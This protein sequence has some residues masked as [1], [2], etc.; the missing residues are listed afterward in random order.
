MYEDFG[1][2][3]DGRSVE[4]SLFLPDNIVDP[5]QYEGDGD[6]RIHSLQVAGTF[7]PH[8]GTTAWDPA[9]APALTPRPHP[10]GVRWT[11]DLGDLPDGLYQYKYVVTFQNGTVRWCGDPCARYIIGPDEDAGFVVGGPRTAVEPIGTRLPLQDLVVYELMLDDFTAEYRGGAAPVDAVQD[12][13]GHLETLGV[14]AVELM[15]WT[16]W[17]GGSF[18]WGYNPFALFAAED[19]YL[20]EAGGDPLRR[21][22]RLKRLVTGLHRRTMHV[23]MDGVFNHVE[24]SRRPDGTSDGRGFAY[25]WLYQDPARSPFTGGFAQGGYFEDLDYNNRCTAQLIFDACRFWL[26]EYQLDGIRLDYTLGFHRPGDPGKGL[27]RLVAELRAHLT[28]SGRDNVT[29]TLEHMADNRYEAIDVANTVGA[30]GCWY[31][32]FLWDVPEA[33][34]H[35]MGTALVRVL[36][37]GQSFAAGRHPVVYVENHDHSTLVSRVGG[38]G[39]WWKAQAPLLALFTSPGAV[40][41]H[42]GQEFGRDEWMPEDGPGRVQPRPLR[43]A[44]LDDEAGG[45]LFALHRQLVRLRQAHPALRSANFHPRP[46]DTRLDRFDADGYGVDTARR[47]AIYH[48]WGKGDDGRLE[49][50]IVVLNFS[51]DDQWTD[52]PFSTNGVWTDLLN[53]DSVDVGGFRLTGQRINS[54]WGRIYH[55]AA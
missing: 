19:R 51:D 55:Q 18:S 17:P 12:R 44:E 14:N 54:N 24:S 45:R 15:P 35:G 52:I 8:L 46:Y 2:R 48:R 49:R 38:R 26:D 43:W 32:R 21:L 39:R 29:L 6:P 41:L 34:S 20:A 47:L 11:V 1:A 40:L 3:V 31:D 37:A 36:D 9:T 5:S 4:L 23:L 13:L 27:A 16:A 50:F 42:N 10:N 7:Q 53:G 28:A 25:H 22:D 30:G 33:A